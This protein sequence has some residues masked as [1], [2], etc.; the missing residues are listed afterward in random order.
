M[1]AARRLVPLARPPSARAAPPREQCLVQSP[2]IARKYRDS[3]RP[4]HHCLRHVLDAALKADG[5]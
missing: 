1:Y 5:V 2:L 3:L 4:V